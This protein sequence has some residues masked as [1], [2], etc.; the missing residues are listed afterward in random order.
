MNPIRTS[1]EIA[2]IRHNTFTVR[3]VNTHDVKVGDRIWAPDDGDWLRVYDI[4]DNGYGDVTF[5]R[6]DR[7]MADFRTG[8]RVITLAE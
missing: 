8:Q 5:L 6:R 1:D 7:S 2:T 3:V 4:K